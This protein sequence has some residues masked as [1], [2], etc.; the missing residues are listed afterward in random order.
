LNRSCGRK[1]KTAAADKSAGGGHWKKVG[2]GR[3]AVS[4]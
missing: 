3:R 2:M 4:R 1:T